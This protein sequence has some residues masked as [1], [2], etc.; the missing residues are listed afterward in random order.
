[1]FL[2]DEA[3]VF[4][5][6]RSAVTIDRNALV[7]VFLREVEYFK[8]IMFLTTNRVDAFDPAFQSRIHI[9]LKYYD[10]GEESRAKIWTAFLK[11]PGTT[12]DMNISSTEIALLAKKKLNG[13]QVRF[14]VRGSFWTGL[15][16]IGI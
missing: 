9:A 6:K 2:L 14:Q 7:S 5:E 13:R 8:G 11:R 4:L 16:L 1:M 3:D 15:L 12:S 10:L